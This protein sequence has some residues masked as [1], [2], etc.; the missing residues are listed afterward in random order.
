MRNSLDTKTPED[1]RAVA[2]EARNAFARGHIE[3]VQ[4]RTNGHCSPFDY[5]AI[6][7]KQRRTPTVFGDPW[8]PKILSPNRFVRWQD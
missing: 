1:I 4:R 5:L 8:Q 3:L 7:R 6:K 2:L